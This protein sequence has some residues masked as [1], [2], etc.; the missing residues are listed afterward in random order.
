MSRIYYK[1]ALYMKMC[2][3][4]LILLTFSQNDRLKALFLR[5][6][7]HFVSNFYNNY[8]P[9]NNFLQQKIRLPD[10]FHAVTSG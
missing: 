4:S 1:Q 6:E 8:S 5:H 2:L 3:N 10:R 9:F 7:E